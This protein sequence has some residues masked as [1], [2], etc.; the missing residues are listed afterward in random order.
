LQTLIAIGVAS[1][2]SL[3]KRCGHAP[4]LKMQIPAYVGTTFLRKLIH[5]FRSEPDP[6]L[7]RHGGQ[8]PSGS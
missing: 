2:V 1:L 8:A 7:I 5:H 6:G 4:E 3:K